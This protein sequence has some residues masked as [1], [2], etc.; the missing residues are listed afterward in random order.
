M[1]V[2]AIAKDTWKCQKCKNYKLSNFFER[3]APSALFIIYLICKLH[4]I[5]QYCGLPDQVVGVHHTPG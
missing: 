5:F 2:N 4:N 3:L 1:D